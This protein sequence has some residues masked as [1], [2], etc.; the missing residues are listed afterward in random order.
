MKTHTIAK[1][2]KKK[3]EKKIISRL[4]S[5]VLDAQRAVLKTRFKNSVL[6]QN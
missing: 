2:K 4:A 1:K 6:S 3:Q 5:I